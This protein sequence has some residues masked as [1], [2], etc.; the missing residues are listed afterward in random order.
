MVLFTAPDIVERDGARAGHRK[1][2]QGGLA[3]IRTASPYVAHRPNCHTA[4]TL[5][6]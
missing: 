6:R 4:N 1:L 3:S 2:A 5:S